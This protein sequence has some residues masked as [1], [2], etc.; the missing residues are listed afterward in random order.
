MGGMLFGKS[1]IDHVTLLITHVCVRAHTHTHKHA[2]AHAR[3]R[4]Q[5]KKTNTHRHTHVPPM[6]R[7]QITTNTMWFSGDRKRE[8][9]SQTRCRLSCCLL[10]TSALICCVSAWPRSRRQRAAPRIYHD[11]SSHWFSIWSPCFH[12]LGLSPSLLNL[13][14]FEDP[15]F[16]HWDPCLKVP[17]M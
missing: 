16:A 11:P 3:A 4:M 7:T 8:R 2:H 6:N 10:W 1:L 9:D 15:C 13:K 12:P 17:P 14:R 5:R